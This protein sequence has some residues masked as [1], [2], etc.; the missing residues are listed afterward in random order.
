MRG[1]QNGDVGS[2]RAYA[3]KA[4]TFT[5]MVAVVALAI[6]MTMG[7]S[8]LVDVRNAGIVVVVGQ[9]VRGDGGRAE[10]HDGGRCRQTQRIEHGKQSCHAPTPLLR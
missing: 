8:V 10:G 1:G 4:A 5:G 2:D 9:A 6:G 3:E 7:R